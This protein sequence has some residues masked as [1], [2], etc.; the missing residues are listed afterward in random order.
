MSRFNLL[1]TLKRL[2]LDINFRMTLDKS[3]LESLLTINLNTVMF[4]ES[5]T[6]QITFFEWMIGHKVHLVNIICIGHNN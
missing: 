4:R 1:S 6:K 2:L 5:I 3:Y